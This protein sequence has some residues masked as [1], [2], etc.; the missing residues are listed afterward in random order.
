[1]VLVGC[2]DSG[3]GVKVATGARIGSV[4]LNEGGCS[5]ILWTVRRSKFTE[6]GFRVNS[7]DQ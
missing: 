5:I 3:D 2:Y 4:K 6:C 1:M 7:D